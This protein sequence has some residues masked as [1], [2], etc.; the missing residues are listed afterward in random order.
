M[1]QEKVLSGL[2]A[3]PPPTHHS[4]SAKLLAW[5]AT[6]WLVVATAGQWLFASYV[7]AFYGRAM[8]AGDLARWNKVLPHGYVQGD[9]FGNLMVGLHV[10]VA[11]IIIVGGPLQLIP[12]VRQY[13]GKFH[14]W[15]GR[16]YLST[17]LL[18][19][20]TGLV[21]V[22]TRGTVGG[23]VQHLA[24]SF[25]AGLILV[26]GALTYKY[27]VAHDFARHR[28]WALRLFM[29]VSGV[30]FFRVGL[31]AW[32]LIHRAPVGFDPDTFEGPFLT[33]LSLS[34]YVVP[35]PV[36]LLELYLRA[37]ASSSPTFRSGVAVGLGL[38]TLLMGLGIVGAAM[39]MWL[40]RLS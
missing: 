35:L 4:T 1:M 2:M 31:M 9:W 11:A 25:N 36:L 6:F 12:Q 40:P 14:R 27:A 23:L 3:G 5:S 21:M 24:I 28:A 34:V 13:A 29:V 37:K 19:A 26:F 32:L 15:N 38:V 18:A 7:V 16:A 39:G 8:A 33:S 17:A 10:T 30:W 20:A 22:W